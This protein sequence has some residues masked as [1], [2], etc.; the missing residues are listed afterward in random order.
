MATTGREPTVFLSLPLELRQSIYTHLL[1]SGRR[2]DYPLSQA[3]H[4][5]HNMV[6]AI[7]A[8]HPIL[9]EEMGNWLQKQCDVGK[10][11]ITPDLAVDVPDNIDW[12]RFRHIDIEITHLNLCCQST[13]MEFR[14]LE[15]AITSLQHDRSGRLPPLKIY[16]RDDNNPYR[17]QYYHKS[18]DVDNADAETG[19]Y[20]VVRAGEQSYIG[21]AIEI[22]MTTVADS[23]SIDEDAQDP[24]CMLTISDTTIPVLLLE[25]FLRLPPCQSATVHSP[26][27]LQLD[28]A[29]CD[30]IRER[31]PKKFDSG[32]GNSIAT[33]L[34]R[35]LRGNREGITLPRGFDELGRLPLEQLAYMR[36]EDRQGNVYS[37]D[38][39]TDY[40]NAQRKA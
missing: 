25:P 36:M 29:S 9:D 10:L 20:E 1:P 34:E 6:R 8:V 7:R 30:Y 15:D 39:P 37:D 4:V 17:N 22:Y 35:W 26:A 19:W 38:D 33:A 11:T 24:V 18:S 12:S 32:Y 14:G 2:A 27:K 40:I 13:T 21:S 5:R 31:P 23:D 28:L 3:D 16:F